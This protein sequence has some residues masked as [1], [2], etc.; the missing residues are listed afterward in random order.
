MRNLRFSSYFCYLFFPSSLWASCGNKN[1]VR[2]CCRVMERAQGMMCR[3]ELAWDQAHHWAWGTVAALSIMT[4][5]IRSTTYIECFPTIKDC[6]LGN[7]VSFA[8]AVFDSF[9][10][11]CS[12][13][14]FSHLSTSEFNMN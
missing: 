6:Y 12:F 9:P 1:R 14:S 13:S 2:Q 7:V 3:E 8:F 11:C 5:I 10:C 4:A